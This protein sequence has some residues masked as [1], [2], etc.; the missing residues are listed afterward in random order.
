MQTTIK[1]LYDDPSCRQLKIEVPIRRAEA[2]KAILT[3][4]RAAS[5]LELHRDVAR[6]IVHSLYVQ[7]A[8]YQR[9]RAAA[10]LGKQHLTHV[11]Y[12]PEWVHTDTSTFSLAASPR[13][14]VTPLPGD[15]R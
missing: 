7:W 14:S 4:F 13:M 3:G 2:I 8:G 12:V 11:Q 9:Y 10:P 5:D 15:D 6:N 1:R